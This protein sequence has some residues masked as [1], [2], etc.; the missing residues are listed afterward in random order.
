MKRDAILDVLKT[1]PANEPPPTTELRHKAHSIISATD[2]HTI[3]QLPTTLLDLLT[4]IIRPLFIK[5]R[6]PNLTSTGRKSL[7]DAPQTPSIGRAFLDDDP[8]WKTPT[9]FTVPL[10][11]YIL[12]SYLT[13]PCNPPDTTLRKTTIEAHF[14]LLVPP[15][16]NMIDDAAPTPYKSAGCRSLALLCEVLTSTQSEI[17]KRSGLADVFVDALK[18]NF[19]LL[20]TLTPE[21]DSLVLLK[22]M[23]AAFLGV[24]DA[25][26]VTLRLK[27]RAPSIQTPASEGDEH[28]DDKDFIPYQ[29]MLTLIYRHGVMASLAH[30]GSAGNA[31]SLSNTMSVPLTVFLL[32]QIPPVF[33]SMGIHA[34]KHF[35]GFLPMLRASLMDPFI[36]MAPEMVGAILDIVD[37]VFDVGRARVQQKW[38]PEVLRGL[39]G[40][41]VNCVDEIENENATENV[42]KSKSTTAWNTR[43]TPLE[44]I[45]A[46]LKRSV[47]TLG[48]IVGP[49]GWSV[50]KTKLVDEEDDLK[51]LFGL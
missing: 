42:K 14:H 29:A 33:A 11:E 15:I 39:V 2:P 3:D 44:D 46:R 13:L 25:R 41:W 35:Q 40:C 6:H 47:Q 31:G 22:E 7:I 34:V 1:T 18:A 8:P 30:L 9:P 28:G 21:A 24:V 50:V 32:R 19:L 20:P 37:C 17:L 23:Y 48:E 12:N 45:M 36:L 10:L 51:A 26:F 38:W 16:L 5:T 43:L 27:L 49:D 4:Q